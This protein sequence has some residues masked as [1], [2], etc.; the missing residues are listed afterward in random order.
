MRCY[1]TLMECIFLRQRHLI[2]IPFCLL[3]SSSLA[4]WYSEPSVVSM[5]KTFRELQYSELGKCCVRLFLNCDD[6][7][8][9]S[10]LQ[11]QLDFW[12]RKK[13]A[14]YQTWGGCGTAV[15]PFLARNSCTDKEERASA[16]SWWRNQSPERHFSRVVF[17]AHV[18]ADAV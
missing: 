7:I 2:A 3:P 4:T 6:V 16:F 13:V 5:L 9:F 11:W 10:S 12:K 18:P 14:G 15:V 1:Q 17:A 8:K